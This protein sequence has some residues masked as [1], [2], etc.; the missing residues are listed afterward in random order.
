MHPAA[1]YETTRELPTD[2]S[3][4][5]LSLRD[6]ARDALSKASRDGKLA[7]ALAK[8]QPV[9]GEMTRELPTDAS[10]RVL[11]LRDQARDAMSKASRDGRL[12][13]A[14]STCQ[15]VAEE[16][17]RQI[18]ADSSS[19]ILSLRD[20]AR[21]A[22]NQALRN[23]RLGAALARCQPLQVRGRMDE[24]TQDSEPGSMAT[25]S[26][27]S[28][29]PPPPARTQAAR[30]SVAH[31]KHAVEKIG[32]VEAF[33]AAPLSP[34]T[35]PEAAHLEV[36]SAAAEEA[37]NRSALRRRAKATLAEAFS[38]GQLEI[39]LEMLPSPVLS[40]TKSSHQVL[41]NAAVVSPAATQSG[42]SPQAEGSPGSKR[43]APALQLD[44]PEDNISDVPAAASDCDEAAQAAQVRR[45][46]HSSWKPS[47][48]SGESKKDA[49]VL[50]SW[51]ASPAYQMLSPSAWMLMDGGSDDEASIVPT[52]RL[53]QFTP[54]PVPKRK[55]SSQISAAESDDL[56]QFMPDR[57]RWP[58]ASSRALPVGYP[59][60]SRVPEGEITPRMSS[61]I[62]HQEFTTPRLT[63]LMPLAPPM[64]RPAP[65]QMPPP[66]GAWQVY[67]SSALGIDDG[68]FGAPLPH[69]LP[70]RLNP[71][72]PGSQPFVE[73]PAGVMRK[74][75]VPHNNMMRW[76]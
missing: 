36:S 45:F 33:K 67:R 49:D 14:L 44:F 63:Q 29:A 72:L 30:A 10:A 75:A 68:M 58:E 50:S 55:P 57:S 11:S 51:S 66:A 20:Q 40:P 35:R 39:A 37:S 32:A 23:G 9:Q 59:D 38:N 70:E 61:F 4:R 25:P 62:P 48:K 65:P 53:T 76:N 64:H 19:R 74:N 22:V 41:D 6:Q 28:T 2:A 43:K 24:S 73:G 16:T 46:S 27:S 21:Q 54:A 69:G 1:Y 17:S 12:A 5:V 15:P 71:G 60:N 42:F 34:E 13:A 7:A 8:C 31:M 52:P 56:L 18:P 26:F 47:V 3:A